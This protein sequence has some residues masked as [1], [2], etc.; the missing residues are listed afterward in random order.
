MAEILLIKLTLAE[1]A[2][3]EEVVYSM[4]DFLYE[5]AGEDLKKIRRGKGNRVLDIIDKL[6]SQ[7]VLQIDTFDQ[8]PECKGKGYKEHGT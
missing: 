7:T 8:C 5:L 2:V 1:I 3:L 6:R 4:E